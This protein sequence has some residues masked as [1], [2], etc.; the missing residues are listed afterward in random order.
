MIARDWTEYFAVHQDRAPR[1]LLLDV[2]SKWPS[3]EGRQAIDLGCGTGSETLGMLHEG[4]SVLAVDAEAVAIDLLLDRVP[5]SDRPRLQTVNAPF[6]VVSLPPAELVHA[7]FSLP[8]CGPERFAVVWQTIQ[9]AVLP[10]GRF[11]GQLFGVRDSWKGSPDMT[12]LHHDEVCAL[13]TE[14]EVEVFDEVDHDGAAV[15]GPKHWHLWHIVARR[16]EF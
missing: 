15:S 10:G 14:W 8:F 1:P 4:W 11:A 3:G 13:L 2:L 6:D 12:F 7:G 16:I 5:A 9:A